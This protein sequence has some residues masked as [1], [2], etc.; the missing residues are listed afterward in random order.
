MRD[1]LERYWSWAR[2]HGT[3]PKRVA[4]RFG[5][6]Y[7]T[8]EVWSRSDYPALLRTLDEVFRQDQVLTL[9]YETLFDEE[10][11]RDIAR[12]L[13]VEPTWP[14]QSRLRPQAGQVMAMPDPP[15][16]LLD[17][18]RPVYGFVHERFGS[19]VPASWRM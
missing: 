4:H 13:Q 12:F 3:E 2:M 6:G 18:L 14:W 11:L 5:A 19:A 1:P 16:E 15:E 8:P 10:V 17:R 7:L 9:F